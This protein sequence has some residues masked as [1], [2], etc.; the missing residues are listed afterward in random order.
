MEK[1]LA[2]ISKCL[3]QASAAF[4][5]DAGIEVVCAHLSEATSMLDALIAQ[6]SPVVETDVEMVEVP[7]KAYATAA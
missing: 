2:E 5:A 7:L 4:E 6:N 3:T 1:E